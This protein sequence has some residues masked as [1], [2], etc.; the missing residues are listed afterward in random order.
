[1]GRNEM[2]K[3]AALT[4]AAAL[5]LGA[6]GCA[7]VE[8]AKGVPTMTAEECYKAAYKILKDNRGVDY[9]IDHKDEANALVLKTCHPKA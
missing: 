7:T 8:P 6:T 2:K 5:L 9:L 4:I 1:M 3:L